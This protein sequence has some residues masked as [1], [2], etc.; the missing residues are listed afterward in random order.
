M[1]GL[2]VTFEAIRASFGPLCVGIDPSRDSLH[3][4]G[5]PDTPDGALEMSLGVIDA[6]SGRVG[7]VK[8]QVGYFERFGAEGFRALES[9][10]SAARTAGLQ[11]IAD[12]KRGDIGSTMEGYAEAWLGDGPLGSDAMTVSPYQGFGALEPA[13]VAAE[14]RG[15]VAFV[16]CA[17]SNIDAA[18]VQ[19]AR[20]GDR[21]LPAE[22]AL[23][24]RE[25]SNN[26][27]T[28]GLVVGAT[29]SLAESGLTE[30]NLVE[31][32]IL[33]PGFGAQGAAL[34]DLTSIF[35]RASSWVIPSVSRSVLRG[36]PDGVA[37]AIESHLA[38]LGR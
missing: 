37:T 12:V 15:S 29:R 22:I 1:S 28:V 19:A 16:L 4:W 18:T 26:D 10:F 2:S 33:S 14:A 35:G 17:T 21:T 36:G 8:P 32:L 34:G 38:E 20:H 7:I 25:R 13:F 30:E 9:V 3:S 6:A 24:A 23:L 5:L 31:S 27:Y 11:I